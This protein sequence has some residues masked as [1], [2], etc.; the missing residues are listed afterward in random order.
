MTDLWK[1]IA[2]SCGGER[3]SIGITADG[4]VCGAGSND[5]SQLDLSAW[6]GI[7]IPKSTVAI[8]KGS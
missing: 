1:N 6:S 3:H 2:A 4:T 8:R 7:G 5:S